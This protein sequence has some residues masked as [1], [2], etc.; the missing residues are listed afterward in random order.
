[1]VGVVIVL[2]RSEPAPVQGDVRDVATHAAPAGGFSDAEQRILGMLP[3]GY[4]AAAC[5]RAAITFPSAIASLDCSQSSTSGSPT[6]ARF[7]LYDDLD[8]LIGDFQS[9]AD[10]MAVAVCPGQNTSPGIWTPAPDPGRIGGG[11]VCG[12][13]QDRPSIA[14]TR[15]ARL[16][17]A[18]VN[19]GPDLNSLYQ[20]WR[21]YVATDQR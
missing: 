20:W 15:D 5:T 6:F 11:I 17:L 12:S 3:A 9:T 21:G 8:A 1:L 4:T 7:T 2:S 14:W 13:V 16:L 19:G 18:T 10:G